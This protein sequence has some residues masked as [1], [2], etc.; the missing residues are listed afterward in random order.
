MVFLGFADDVLNLKWRHKLTLPTVA[1]LPLLLVYYINTGNTTVIVPRILVGL[2]G[3][4][5]D[6][7]NDKLIH[8]KLLFQ[9][10]IT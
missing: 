9:C 2:F 1:S 6:L 10:F 8:F 7:G 5:I 4:D 3:K